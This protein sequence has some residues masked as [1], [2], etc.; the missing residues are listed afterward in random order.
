M[1]QIGASRSIRTAPELMSP[2]RFKKEARQ[3]SLIG[4]AYGYFDEQERN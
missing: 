1:E 3:Q 2:Q 4:A